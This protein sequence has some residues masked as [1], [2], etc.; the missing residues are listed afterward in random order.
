MKITATII[1][2]AL[3]LIISSFN[4]KFDSYNST[5]IITC[6]SIPALNKSIVTFVKTQIGKKVGRGECWDVAAQALNFVNAKWDGKYKF[7]KEINYKNDCVFPGDILQ[8]EGITLKYDIDSKH[9]M[10]K[11]P[12][13]TAIVYEVKGGADFVMADQNT[14]RSGKKVGLSPINLKDI[15][16]GKFK[17]FRPTL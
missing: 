11:L 8:F 10:E 13:H 15:T 6:D 17:I 14:G 7:G 1:L 2:L 16:Q 4:Y 3:F 9:Y 12:H 5:K